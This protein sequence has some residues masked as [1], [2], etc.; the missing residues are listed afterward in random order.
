MKFIMQKLMIQ[1]HSF[2]TK[3]PQLEHH[4]SVVLKFRQRRLPM[5][6][7]LLTSFRTARQILHPGE[8]LLLPHPSE[9]VQGLR[10]VLRPRQLHAVHGPVLLARVARPPDPS[11]ALPHRSQDRPAGQGCVELRRPG[12][13]GHLGLTE[14]AQPAFDRSRSRGRILA[15]LPQGVSCRAAGGKARAAEQKEGQEGGVL[16]P[17]DEGASRGRG[18]KAAERGHGVGG[19][20]GAF[21]AVVERRVAQKGL[22]RPGRGVV[23]EERGALFLRSVRVRLGVVVD[24]GVVVVVLVVHRGGRRSIGPP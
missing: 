12:H 10:L 11:A 9:F 8:E 16:Q 19:P 1:L 23:A 24:E 15:Q 14:G 6:H 5:F 17:G 21:P 22:A 20:Q 3:T 18:A 2:G 7:I 4:A 13:G